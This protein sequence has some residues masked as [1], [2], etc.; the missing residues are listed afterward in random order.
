MM[1]G[2]IKRSE[3]EAALRATHCDP[4][5]TKFYWVLLV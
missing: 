2:K 1:S 4:T 3:M 5:P